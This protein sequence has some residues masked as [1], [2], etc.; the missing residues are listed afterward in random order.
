MTLNHVNHLTAVEYVELDV[1]ENNSSTSSLRTSQILS[2]FSWNKGDN[3]NGHSNSNFIVPLRSFPVSVK[4]AILTKPLFS[5]RSIYVHTQISNS[6][7]I[8]LFI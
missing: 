3:L 1:S 6:N 2:S 5:V 7:S 4:V 8:L